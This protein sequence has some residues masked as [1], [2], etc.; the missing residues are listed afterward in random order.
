M[1]VDDEDGRKGENGRIFRIFFDGHPKVLP[2]NHYQ[3]SLIHRMPNEYSK[4]IEGKDGETMT[5][6]KKR[7]RTTLTFGHALP[8]GGSGLV[9][10]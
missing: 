1:A 5:K 7:R 6:I 4:R 9:S 8:S 10:L 2:K 3:H